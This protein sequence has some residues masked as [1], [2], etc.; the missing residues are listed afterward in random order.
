[1]TGTWGTAYLAAL[2]SA[3][4]ALPFFP[5]PRRF[6]G[7]TVRQ[8]VRLRRA[9]RAGRLALSNEFGR[10]PLVIDAVLVGNG[11]LT[12]TTPALRR[13]AGKWEIPAGATAI[14]DPIRLP[15]TMRA[16][17]A[18]GAAVDGAAAEH[19]AADGAAAD[20]ELVV[21][22][23]VSGTAEAATF[24][25][26]AQQT[27]EVA[28]G[29]QLG[30]P[31]LADSER[32]TALYWIARVLT[33]RPASGPVVVTLGDSITRGDG[34]T[35]DLDQRYP[36][37]LQ[38]RLVGAGIG[39]AVVLNAGI[40]GNRLLRAVVGPSMTDR[41]DRDVL[42]AGQATH[43]LILAGTNDIA[44]PAMLGETRPAAGDI[45]DGLRGLARRADRGGVRPV[46]G[47]ITPFGGSS[48][49]AFG[50]DGN[51]DVRLAVNA[52]ITAQ[53]DW[54]VADFAAALADPDDPGRLA[55][56]FDSGDGVH[57]GDAGARALAAAVDLGVFT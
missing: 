54:P 14:S 33:D 6:A 41:F 39:D 12:S 17:T 13:G 36:D 56:A 31:R 18:E 7:Q 50:A 3:D 28:P 53:T 16:A 49:D 34:T 32:F 15:M 30:R 25:H 9:G 52:A 37:H 55:A 10:D 8:R 46:L 45:I 47:T 11:D 22:C 38:R 23:F 1:M 43:V 51:E 5:P 21:D 44:L 24:L 57:P 35:I 19:E 42:G 40:G 26:S 27:G 48:I 29:D 4:D 2:A 20:G